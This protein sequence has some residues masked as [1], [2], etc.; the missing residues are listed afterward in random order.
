LSKSNEVKGVVARITGAKVYFNVK[1]D[2]GEFTHLVNM[3]TAF[4]KDSM[5][6]IELGG[7][8]T[9]SVKLRNDDKEKITIDCL[10]DDELTFD[11]IDAIRDLLRKIKTSGKEYTNFTKRNIEIN[12]TEISTDKTISFDYFNELSHEYPS[13]HFA[14][15]TLYA[16]SWELKV[17]DFSLG[18]KKAFEEAFKEVNK[19]KTKALSAEPTAM[20]EILK[21]FKWHTYKMSELHQQV[22]KTEV[23]KI[24]ELIRTREREER[25]KEYQRTK[26]YRQLQN[27][28]EYLQQLQKELR[29][30][31]T[32]KTNWIA[33]KN[34][35]INEISY[36]ISI[37]K[38]QIRNLWKARTHEVHSC[39]AHKTARKNQN[40]Q[41][42]I[43]FP[44][45][46][47]NKK[48]FPL[49]EK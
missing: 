15:R 30:I 8:V 43:F 41:E 25:N 45:P 37:L 47:K 29:E 12:E 38:M 17:K 14:L 10:D 28:E 26:L 35:K 23:D 48:I 42:S 39:K 24:W 21:E 46:E 34:Q 18:I 20:Q 19:L 33:T 16:E 22:I 44:T 13:L 3:P 36:E 9:L 49:K 32:Y 27:Q 31:P 4:I 1:K 40:L 7:E 6:Y 2:K 11:E 5:K